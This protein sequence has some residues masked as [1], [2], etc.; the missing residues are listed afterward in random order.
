MERV[1][2]LRE[3]ASILR[4]L[5]GSFDIAPI[6]NQLLDLAARCNELAQSIESNPENAGIDPIR[7]M[8]G[9]R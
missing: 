3:Q 4:A 2:T 5:A 6:R 1:A 8:A 9:Q 7:A